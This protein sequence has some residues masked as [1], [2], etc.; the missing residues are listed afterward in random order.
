MSELTQIEKTGDPEL[1]TREF[2]SVKSTAD[3]KTLPRYPRASALYHDCMRQLVLINRYE[4]VDT[5][6]NKFHQNIVFNIGNAVH[7]WAQ[8]T[9]SFISDEYRRGLWKCRSCGFISEFSP[10]ISTK[11]P[12]CSARK[13]SFE[14]YEYPLKLET[15]LFLT[16]HPDMFVE[17]PADNFR[18]VEFKTINGSDFDKLKAPLIE[19]IW[20]VHAYMW[21]LSKDKLFKALPFD[22]KV[23]YIMYI[24]K[25][26]KINSSPIKTFIVQRDASIEKDILL[27]LK[28]FKEGYLGGDIPGPCDT[29]VVS[30]FSSYYSKN[31]PALGHC[32]KYLTKD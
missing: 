8:N 3:K 30:E 28:E 31:C 29:C 19:H 11:C 22:K 5:K 17:K 15:P 27:K 16:G 9:R 25:G 32:K 21:G 2:I 7:F 24:S 20:Q 14:Y 6:Y 10:I 12:V 23:S 4:I 18:I 26:M 13:T 1:I